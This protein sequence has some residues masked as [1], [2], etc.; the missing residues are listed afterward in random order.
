MG[1][2]DV[3]GRLRFLCAF[4]RDLGLHA[5]LGPDFPI[6]TLRNPHATY[7]LLSYTLFQVLTAHAMLP[8]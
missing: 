4:Q 5:I 6:L 2:D 7:T 3:T 8:D 1:Y